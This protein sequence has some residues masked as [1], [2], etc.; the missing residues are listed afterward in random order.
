MKI[1]LF[2]F[3]FILEKDNFDQQT[4]LPNDEKAYN[5]FNGYARIFRD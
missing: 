5:D 1:L 4:K 2:C 3:E